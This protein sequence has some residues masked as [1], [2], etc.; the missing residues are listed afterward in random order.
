[1]DVMKKLF[2]GLITLA[3]FFTGNVN[4]IKA[5][6]IFSDPLADSAD[7]FFLTSPSANQKVKNNVIINVTTF[8]DEQSQISGSVELW[9]SATC[10][11]SRQGSISSP[12][13]FQSNKTT[14]NTINWNT[15][16]I[17]DGE[18]CL[19]ICLNLKNETA[20]Y[21]ACNGRRVR[22]LNTNKAPTITSFPQNLTVYENDP[23]EYDLNATDPDGDKITYRLVQTANFLSIDPNTGLIKRGSPSVTFS[24]DITRYDYTIIVA[25]DDNFAGAATQQ[26]VLSILK[27]PAPVTPPSNPPSNPPV[28]PPIVPDPEPE[29]TN[30][31]AQITFISP[32][33]N[34]ILRGKD[35]LVQWRIVDDEK[36]Q[37]GVLLYAADGDIPEY[38][39]IFEFTDENITS[40]NWNVSM[41][42]N[43]KYFL[44]LSTVD[45]E[46]VKTIKASPI[47]NIQN[48]TVTPEPEQGVSLIEVK[49]VTPR[50]EATVNIRRP[51]LGGQFSEVEDLSLNLETFKL[52][53]N[54]E[55]I[56]DQCSV[57]S[58]DY[59]CELNKD[60]SDGEYS[61]KVTVEDSVGDLVTHESKFKV[62]AEEEIPSFPIEEGT[63]P[64]TV[65]IF[66]ITLPRNVV[67]LVLILIAVTFLLLFIPW[68]LLRIWKRDGAETDSEYDSST[69]TSTTTDYTSPYGSFDTNSYYLQSTPE[70]KEIEIP[71]FSTETKTEVEKKPILSDYPEPFPKYDKVETKTET[72][73][74]KEPPV[75]TSP[76]LD[77][78]AAAPVVPEPAPRTTETKTETTVNTSRPLSRKE[79]RFGRNEKKNIETRV[80]AEYSEPKVAKSEEEK[81]MEEY[82]KYIN[83]TNTE[84]VE[85]KPTDF[86]EPT[87]TDVAEPVPSTPTTPEV[88]PVTQ[89]PVVPLKSADTTAD[90]SA[91]T[92]STPKTDTVVP[93]VP[94][95][96]EADKVVFIDTSS[97][98]SNDSIYTDTTTE[99]TPKSD[100]PKA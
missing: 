11:S 72:S 82:Y 37:S 30:T 76:V 5:N 46:G 10:R 8:D 25:A 61:V 89:L 65:T 74:T 33:E 75:Y 29:E 16:S 26:F 70:K 59:S 94:A 1:M 45:E 13:T 63:A 12:A 41:I 7:Q 47:F 32:K 66:G 88:A 77:T 71:G 4:I 28:N 64:D 9:D 62:D 38:T 2:L 19:K 20:P 24:G 17:S 51:I 95:N 43:G 57:S 100:E 84:L 60:L 31:A 73:V 22:V 48:T 97:V 78:V 80:T 96:K 58:I 54:G 69:T 81:V 40:F 3:V 99:Y 49:E 15:T 23:W 39:S 18:Y 14:G 36:L 6:D 35:N 21:L 85:P 79:R 67:N 27:R 98:P 93:P 52:E 53:L 55:N 68:V 92:L 42:P 34:Q 87:P 91:A 44:S 50:N 56:S 90:S 86:V 83:P